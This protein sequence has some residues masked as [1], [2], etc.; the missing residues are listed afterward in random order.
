MKKIVSLIILVVLFSSCNE[1]QKALK[2]EDVALK[3]DASVKM[4]EKGKYDKAIR[5][6]EQIAPS[7][8][9][10]PQAENLFYMFSQAYYKT[11]QYYLAGY[12]FESFASSYPKS[13]KHEEAAF[14]GAKCYS[15]LSPVY[16]LDQADT[17]K[18]V[19][20]LQNFI[21]SY[22]NSTYLAEANTVVKSLRNKI[23]KKA[24]ENAKQYNTISD[25]K[26][27][28]IALDNF[29]SD[30]PGT[31]F[32]EDALF[33]KLDSAYQLAINSVPE[34]MEERLNTAK[35][36]YNNFTKFSSDSKYKEKA[37]GMIAK[38]DKDLQQFSK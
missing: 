30:Y 8:K 9:G 38:I 19:D 20:K 18:A 29:I 37:S 3:Y 2:S 25:Y 5:L 33:Y 16:S 1:Y 36:A 34:K 12:Q 23:E 24:F 17:D 28:Q 21:D 35:A 13:E 26:S 32:K 27:A 10:K 15:M 7:Y 31:P 11:K 6:F 14:L 4:Y 22:P